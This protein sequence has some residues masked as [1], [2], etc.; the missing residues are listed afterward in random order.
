MLFEWEWRFVD[1]DLWHE[2]PESLVFTEVVRCAVGSFPER[3]PQCDLLGNA[4]VE[5]VP[6][7]LFRNRGDQREWVMRRRPE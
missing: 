5:G 7:I 4:T 1:E 6:A 2:M 3:P